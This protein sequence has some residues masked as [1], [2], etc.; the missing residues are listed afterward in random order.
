VRFSSRGLARVYSGYSSAY[1]KPTSF[2][3]AGSRGDIALDAFLGSG[4]T[5]IAAERTGRSCSG[6]ELDPLYVD[7]IIRRWQ[8]LTGE[9]ARHAASGRRLDDLAREAEAANAV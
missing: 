1:K 4:T 9:S 2:W 3:G 8:T 6:M 5:M 7:R